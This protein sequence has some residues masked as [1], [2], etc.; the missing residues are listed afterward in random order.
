MKKSL[1]FVA[2]YQAYIYSNDLYFNNKPFNREDSF[3]MRFQYQF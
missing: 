2:N 1:C 3:L